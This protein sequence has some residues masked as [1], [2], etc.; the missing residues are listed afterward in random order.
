MFWQTTR[1]SLPFF[2]GFPG[3]ATTSIQNILNLLLRNRTVRDFETISRVISVLGLENRPPSA[4]NQ[5]M[6]PNDPAAPVK[7]PKPAL[8][9]ALDGES[10][11]RPPVWFMRQA[12]RFLPEYRAIRRQA[13]FEEVLYDADLSA[14]VTLQPLRR[15][16]GIDAAIIFSDILVVLQAL[17]CGVT[18]PGSPGTLR[19]RSC[20]GSASW[21]VRR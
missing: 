11:S 15:F 4:F 21:P 12:G 7:N 14:E 19:S 1:P 8:L 18:I 5:G 20:W 6:T 10:L 13:T 17:G 9:R 16:P 3:L 2:P